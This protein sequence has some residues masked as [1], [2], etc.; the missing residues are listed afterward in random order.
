MPPYSG[1]VGFHEGNLRHMP[2]D[3]DPCEIYIYTVDMVGPCDSNSQNR[4]M[5][6][7]LGE[8]LEKVTSSITVKGVVENNV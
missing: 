5:N 6:I 3:M 8:G 2:E 4:K 7:S 1:I